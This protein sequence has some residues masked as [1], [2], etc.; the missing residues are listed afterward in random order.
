[1]HTWRTLQAICHI[2]ACPQI[3]S[4]STLHGHGTHKFHSIV[5]YYNIDNTKISNGAR[6]SLTTVR[7]TANTELVITN[8][9]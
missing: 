1:M 2:C 6:T 5:K 4:W 3:C 9:N 8:L 7:Y